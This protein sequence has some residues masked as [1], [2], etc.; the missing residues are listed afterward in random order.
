MGAG[1]SSLR[2]RHWLCPLY[3]FNCDCE[4]VDLTDG[5]QIKHA[6]SELKAHLSTSYPEW[7]SAGVVEYMVEL[8]QQSGVVNEWAEISIKEAAER[9]SLLTDLISA[10]RLCHAGMVALG[11]LICAHPKATTRSIFVVYGEFDTFGW[12]SIPLGY[13]AL[14]DISEAEIES[15]S[16]ELPKYEFHTS[17]VP[18]VNKLMKEIRA[19]R[20]SGKFSALHE[21]LRRFNCAYQ[22]EFKDRL[23]DQMIAFESLYLGYDQ[24]LKYRLALRAAFLLGKDEGERTDI[25]NNMRKVYKL[26]SDI[27]HGN[28]EVN[29]QELKQ[30]IPQTEE[31]LRQSIRRFLSLLSKGH[32]L[33][34]L[35]QETDKGLA[36]LD[37]NILSNGVLLSPRE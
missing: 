14:P 34:S 17:D 1:N 21:A 4:S 27:V 25:F 9:H 26:R 7:D 35:R 18:K 37:E 36:K 29:G 11:P 22:G 19:Y 24:E 31:Y 20:L 28:K 32:S 16:L 3:S 10:L 15:A 5:I 8:P 13:E 6:L 2:S 33:K 12:H 23:I 30:I